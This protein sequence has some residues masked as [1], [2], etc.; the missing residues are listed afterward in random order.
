MDSEISM[1]TGRL[2]SGFI[3]HS[4]EKA[5][6]E[7]TLDHRVLTVTKRG[8]RP[9]RERSNR[10]DYSIRADVIWIE[11]TYVRMNQIETHLIWDCMK[12][13][14]GKLWIC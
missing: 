3:I 7:L 8:I 5:A 9:G 1:S 12:G 4:A 13:L 14:R 6:G 10:L 2:H 11:F